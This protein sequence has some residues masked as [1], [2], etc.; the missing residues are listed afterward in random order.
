M[1]LLLGIV[2]RI[3]STISLWGR[4][5]FCPLEETQ[6]SCITL[7]P[8]SSDQ[9]LSQHPAETLMILRL[10][11]HVPNLC[12]LCRHNVLHWMEARCFRRKGDI[13]WC[14]KLEMCGKNL[15][16]GA[17]WFKEPM[18]LSLSSLSFVFAFLL[19]P[20]CQLILCHWC[21]LFPDT[22]TQPREVNISTVARFSTC[23]PPPPAPSVF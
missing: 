6:F 9:S 16:F 14:L 8:K 19:W 5:P 12:K 4:V 18:F 21:C 7:W 1:P 13:W 17:D 10:D 3:P 15:I 22:A 11:K 23:S 2:D 20:V